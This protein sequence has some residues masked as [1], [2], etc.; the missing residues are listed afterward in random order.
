MTKEELEKLPKTALEAR[1]IKSTYY[2]TNIP[3]CHGHISKRGTNNNR[4]HICKKISDKKIKENLR[5]KAFKKINLTDKICCECCGE[6][7]YKFL[8]L[9]HLN[10]NGSKDRK[11]YSSWT[12]LKRILKM[13]NSEKEYR[14]LCFNCNNGRVH[15]NGICP[16]KIKEVETVVPNLGE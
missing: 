6:C 3:C 4:C 1:K 16:H 13:T 5:K 8:C 7:E 9:D 11:K 10:N 14:I 12:I 2:F 15:N